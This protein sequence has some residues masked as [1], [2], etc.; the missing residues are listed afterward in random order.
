MA[1]F[2]NQR[3]TGKNLDPVNHCHHKGN[4]LEIQILGFLFLW[5]LVPGQLDTLQKLIQKVLDQAR[6]LL[7]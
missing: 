4:P 1:K 2:Q 3:G 5:K 7:H 6:H